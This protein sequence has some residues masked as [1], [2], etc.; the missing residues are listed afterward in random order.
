MTDRELAESGVAIDRRQPNGHL[1]RAATIVLALS[2]LALASTPLMVGGSY[3]ILD[4]TLSE[5][6]G[7]EVDGA[8]LFRTGVV[9]ASAG[10]FM[11]TY[12]AGEVWP[13]V[14]RWLLRVYSLALL[15]AV[16][17]SE[18]PWD[19][20]PF[21]ETE[22]FLHTVF[23]VSAATA[24]IIGILAVCRLRPR[25]HRMAKVFDWLVVLAIALLPQVSLITEG[26]GAMQRVLVVLGYSW[27]FIEAARIM[28]AH[29][30]RARVSG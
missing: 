28:R 11:L 27:L 21:D 24:F 16:W 8:W 9:L 22:A 14:S 18:S 30:T 2:A 4:H 25:G 15:G 12:A 7:Q 17:F 29:P 19:G 20:R 1:A 5:S 10:V 13:V 3:S 6:G 23:T 26:D